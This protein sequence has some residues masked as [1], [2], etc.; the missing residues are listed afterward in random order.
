MGEKLRA[1]SGAFRV[2]KERRLMSRHQA[3]ARIKNRT[4]HS[5]PFDS[6][7]V[8]KSRLESG[9]RGGVDRSAQNV[10]LN[11]R[12][13]RCQIGCTETGPKIAWA[14]LPPRCKSR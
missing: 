6:R 4:S 5:G 13:R 3:L 8:I 11:L 12:T 9:A 10:I 1:G 7:Q 14:P 2:P